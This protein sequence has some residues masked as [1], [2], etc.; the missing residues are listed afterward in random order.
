MHFREEAAMS[1]SPF[2][3]YMESI[4]H[5]AQMSRYEVVRESSDKRMEFT[6]E[7]P[8][9]VRPLF[10]AVGTGNKVDISA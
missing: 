6:A 3:D 4:S 8:K 2:A 10:Q 9:L 5:Q 7:Q 1:V